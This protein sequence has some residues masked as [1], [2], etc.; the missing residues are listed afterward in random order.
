MS[1]LIRARARRKIGRRCSPTAAAAAAEQWHWT[2]GGDASAT[3][4]MIESQI[5]DWTTDSEAME[6]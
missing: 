2:T 4:P 5:G 3:E 1:V 6:R